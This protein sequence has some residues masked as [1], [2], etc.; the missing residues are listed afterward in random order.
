MLPRWRRPS[1]LCNRRLRCRAP[2]TFHW[3]ADKRT[4]AAFAIEHLQA[5]AP[6]PQ[7]AISLSAGAP[8]GTIAVNRDTCTLCLACVGA[9]PEGAIL[10][11]AQSEVPQLRF[12]ESKCVQCGLCEATC[13]EDAITLTPRLSLA[14]EAKEPR[15]LNEASIFKCIRC[16][17]ALGT[18]KMIGNMLAKLAGHSMFAA[19]GSLDRLQDVRRLSRD[20]HDAQ[21]VERSGSGRQRNAG[22]GPAMSG[23]HSPSR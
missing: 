9:C 5:H 14:A 15:V 16:G 11:H 7:V 13:P 2:A 20:R 19:P 4:T 1:G 22:V 23:R 18:D 21:G 6:T 8:F 3:S 10:D 12:I 17:K